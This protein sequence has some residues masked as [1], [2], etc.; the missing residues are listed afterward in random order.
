MKLLLLRGLRAQNRVDLKLRLSTWGED[1]TWFGV[2]VAGVDGLRVLE[3]RGP[4]TR[5]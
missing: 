5:L 4:L 3:G 1:G 2:V